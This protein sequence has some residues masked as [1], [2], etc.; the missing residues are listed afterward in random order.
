MIEIDLGVRRRNRARGGVNSDMVGV[1]VDR[2]LP[3][4]EEEEEGEE[5]D[6][7]DEEEV[8]SSQEEGEYQVDEVDG[9]RIVSADSLQGLAEERLAAPPW[10]AM[11]PNLLGG[12]DALEEGG[13]GE[14]NDYRVPPPEGGRPQ[15]PQVPFP[16]T[17]PWVD[18]KLNHCYQNAG[19]ERGY[20]NQHSGSW[21]SSCRAESWP[22]GSG[23]GR[24]SHHRAPARWCWSS[25]KGKSSLLWKSGST[26]SGSTEN[27]KVGNSRV[28]Q[29]TLRLA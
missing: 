24:I 3:R 10:Q 18:R 20:E 12:E 14:P 27:T 2:E 4:E 11:P 25:R 16:Q 7:N 13:G 6:V 9:E 22:R 17:L 15:P 5:G 8:D 28:L 1:T 29:L 19:G 23:E 21:S 26:Q